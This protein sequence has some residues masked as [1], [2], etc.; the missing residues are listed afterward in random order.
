MNVYL[1]LATRYGLNILGLLGVSVAL[2]LGS[3]IFIPLTIAGLLAAILHPAALWL[4]QRLY[5]PWFFSCLAVILGLVV[6]NLLLMF[7]VGASIPQIVDRIPSNDEQWRQKYEQAARQIRDVSPFP[8][9]DALPLSAANSPF[10]E[11]VKRLFSPE[12]IVPV[13]QSFALKSFAYIGEA[14]LI[15]FVVLFLLL[16]GELLAKKVRAIF[17]TSSDSNRRVTEAISEMGEAIRTYLVW[18]TIINILLGLLVG[19]IYR[20]LGLEQ[21][22]LWAILTVILNYVPYIGTIAAGVPPVAEALLSGNT[23]IALGIIIGYTLIV[24]FE[25]YWIVP[26]VMG[27]TMDLNATTVMISCLY[28]HLVW[29]IAGLFLAMPLMAALKAILTHVDGWQAWGDLLS[30]VDTTPATLPHDEAA[31][32]SEIARQAQAQGDADATIIMSTQGSDAAGRQ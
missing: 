29:G 23:G 30:S 24:T 8:T 18:R 19:V 31:Q 20:F 2:Y 5:F 10:F 3:S 15:L 9:E 32:L 26:R 12:N 1:T 6:I 13:L 21:W 22:Y 11:S 27:K 4:H 25:G 16:E 7:A 14:V 28:W 17:G